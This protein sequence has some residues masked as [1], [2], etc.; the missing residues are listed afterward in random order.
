MKSMRWLRWCG[1]AMLACAMNGQAMNSSN[2]LLN[3]G[4]TRYGTDDQ[5][6]AWGLWGYDQSDPEFAQYASSPNSWAF[7]YEAGIWQDAVTDFRPGDKLVVNGYLGSPTWDP[8]RNGSKAGVVDV[9]FWNADAFLSSIRAAPTINATNASP[10]SFK[11]V[12]PNMVV[13]VPSNASSARV[14]VR[15]V[16]YFTGDGR[17]FADELSAVNLNGEMNL[18]AGRFLDVTTNAS[19]PPFGWTTTGAAQGA[20]YGRMVSPGGAWQMWDTATMQ[21]QFYGAWVP[22][23]KVRFGA[24]ALTPSNDALRSGLKSG[25]V[26]L[27]FYNNATSLLASASSPS[28]TASNV[29]DRWVFLSGTTTAPSNAT[30]A[31]LILSCDNGTSGLGRV[32]FDNPFLAGARSDVVDDRVWGAA[33]MAL[34]GGKPAV[35]YEQGGYLSFAINAE[36]NGSGVWNTMN[37]AA[38]SPLAGRPSLAVVNGKPA[39]AFAYGYFN[40]YLYIAL[41]STA[42]GM[43]T[44]TVVPVYPVGTVGPGYANIR[45]PYLAVVNGAPVITFHNDQQQNCGAADCTYYGIW[46]ARCGSA[47]GASNWNYNTYFARSDAASNVMENGSVITIGGRYMFA[48]VSTGRAYLAVSQSTNISPQT[49]YLIDTNAVQ[50]QVSLAAVGGRP[51][52]AYRSASGLRYA[53]STNATGAGTWSI[54]TVDTAGGTAVGQLAVVSNRPSIAYGILTNSQVKLATANT[55]TGS[56]TWSNRVVASGFA[57]RGLVN[58][59]NRPGIIYSATNGTRF[60]RP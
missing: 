1:A 48:Y 32:I 34:V 28:I 2:L 13:T 49:T 27:Q 7:W 4:V 19:Q 47:S 10:T 35:A 21:Q 26:T 59:V 60:V 25:R 37:V 56:G 57:A 11:W 42:D 18:L 5:P 24:Y 14:V 46:F 40:A 51:A 6:W 44:W 50:G 30:A 33:S 45:D 43:G 29:A 3:G 53:Y 54:L 16:D 58:L 39:I 12:N 20:E 9:E 22:G 31:R 15:C 38:I 23:E 55:T 36:T 8:L 41:S 52:M 17:F